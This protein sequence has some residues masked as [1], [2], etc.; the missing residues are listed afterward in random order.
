M[1]EKPVVEDVP[2]R[3]DYQR[4]VEGKIDDALCRLRDVANR[5]DDEYHHKLATNVL[6]SHRV[7]AQELGTTDTTASEDGTTDQLEAGTILPEE[8]THLEG[9]AENAVLSLR[10]NADELAA[11]DDIDDHLQ[12]VIDGL[13]LVADELDA[14][15]EQSYTSRE[16]GTVKRTASELSQLEAMLGWNSMAIFSS[17]KH[18]DGDTLHLNRDTTLVVMADPYPEYTEIVFL[19]GEF[20]HQDGLTANSYEAVLRDKFESHGE[21]RIVPLSA[22][23]CVGRDDHGSPQYVTPDRDGEQDDG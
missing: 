23:D 2:D 1:T 10:G 22:V 20:H 21:A 6:A 4:E 3:P 17:G 12:D 18:F 9:T 14:A 16:S 15:V 5:A 8:Q 19:D 13:R 11:R 7:S